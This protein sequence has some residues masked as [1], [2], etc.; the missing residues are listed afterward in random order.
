M[1]VLNSSEYKVAMLY[2][3]GLSRQEI[4]VSDGDQPLGGSSLRHV[5][6]QLLWPGY[7]VGE[8]SGDLS[9]GLD[10]VICFVL[11]NR[12]L[13]FPGCLHPPPL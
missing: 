13:H 6:A 5:V 10:F 4:S 12:P 11:I 2:L 8:M 1:D 9:S 7:E 3:V